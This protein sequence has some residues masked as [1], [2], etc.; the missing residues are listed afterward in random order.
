MGKDKASQV[1]LENL[2]R[3]DPERVVVRHRL[4]KKYHSMGRTEDAIAQLGAVADILDKNDNREGAI[5]VLQA[6][7]AL[8]PDNVVEYQYKLKQLRGN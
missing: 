6:I 4:A 5:Q 7:L 1:F 8:K 3:E 2:V